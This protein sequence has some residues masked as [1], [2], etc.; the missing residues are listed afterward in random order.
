M[1]RTILFAT[2]PELPALTDDD[3]LAA[4]ALQRRGFTVE[5]LVWGE[6]GP[7]VRGAT[8]VLRSCWDYHLRPG[9]FVAWIDGLTAAGVTL[10]NAAPTLREN[11]HKRYLLRLDAA[12]PPT[13]LV[14]RGS[15]GR[16][17]AIAGR[18][19]AEELVIKPA[20]SLSAFGT[21]RATAGDATA[22]ARFAAQLAGGDL[23]V[24]R[25][26]PEVVAGELSLVY[27]AGRYS[28]C[29]RKIPAPGDFRVQADFG[30]TR[31]PWTPDVDT[32]AAAG[33]IVEQAA[34]DTVYCRVDGV[35][36]AAGFV[37]MELELIDPVLFFA[38]APGAVER[39]VAALTQRLG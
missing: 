7:D 26:V 34:A 18:L 3:R 8:V 24:Q 2:S 25:F 19:G 17:A 9:A 22:E 33:R 5:P 38:Y 23:L 32:L 21:W 14:P 11:L 35:R 16:L 36:T 28:H 12:I 1:S 37:L 30:G 20:I 10:V 31:Q 4:L 27:F 15:A 29:V 39:F 6:A 13:E